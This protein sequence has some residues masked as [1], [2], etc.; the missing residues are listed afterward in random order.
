MNDIKTILAQAGHYIN[1]TSGGIVPPIDP[2]ATFARDENLDLMGQYLYSRYQNPSHDQL[3][4]VMC[5]LENGIS[6]KFFS[7]GLAAI[8][9]VFETVRPGEHIVAPQIMYH[10]AQDWLRRIAERRGIGLKFFNPGQADSIVDAVIPGR[11]NIVWIESPVNPSFDVIDIEKTAEIAHAAGATLGVDATCAPPVTTRA[12]DFGAD[13]VVHSAT[14]YLN[15]HSD[16]NAGVIVTQK[17]DDRWAEILTTRT[18]SGAILGSFD[19]WLLLRGMRTMA[20]RFER[21]S[22]NAMQIAQFLESHEKVET[23]MYPGLPSHPTHPIAA[24]QMKNGYG[25]MMSILMKGGVEAAHKLAASVNV[26]VRATSLGGVES[27]IEHRRTVEGPNSKVPIQLLR[28]SVGIEDV[29]DL[30]E[31]LSQALDQV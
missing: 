2:S 4:H 7:S 23:V 9:A 1:R 3:E 30:I 8:A 29:N 27:L 14:K 24:R 5:Q 21:A 28:I 15:G 6:A 17:E 11:T 31:D 26:F 13:L 22:E 18:H 25:G 19:A 10:G 20:I 16:L 12:F